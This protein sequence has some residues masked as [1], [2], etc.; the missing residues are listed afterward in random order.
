MIFP[1]P[2]AES[3]SN[4]PYTT[5]N[6]PPSQ[7]SNVASLHAPSSNSAVQAPYQ[8]SAYM[9]PPQYSGG[10]PV[11][12]QQLSWD[13]PRMDTAYNSDVV[14][15]HYRQQQQQSTTA[16]DAAYYN[17]QPTFGTSVNP[18]PAYNPAG[19]SAAGE[20]RSM[21]TGG[22]TKKYGA[23]VLRSTGPWSAGQE[24]EDSIYR[25][26]ITLI[27]SA[28]HCISLELYFALLCYCVRSVWCYH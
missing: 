6:S 16:W 11:D 1:R 14:L 17:P 2:F 3:G 18:A 13:T 15:G 10:A 23:L 21:P 25:A 5:I 19:N 28:R 26:Y 12:Y 22:N 20:G 4:S 9:S 8:Q 27:M 24:F 7:H